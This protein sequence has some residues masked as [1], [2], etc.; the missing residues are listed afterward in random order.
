MAY[1]IKYTYEKY[2]DE[3]D[4]IGSDFLTIPY[5]MKKI[6]SSTYDFI[7]K[8]IKYIENTEEISEDIR[9]LYKPFSLNTVKLEEKKWGIVYPDDFMYLLRANVIDQ[10]VVVR[11]TN[12]IR[13][14]QLDIYLRNPHT[15]PT[16]HYPIVVRNS[17]ILTIISDGNPIKLDGVYVKKPIFGNYAE[18]IDIDKEIIVNLPDIAVE[19]ILQ[20]AVKST[21]KSLNDERYDAQNRETDDFR[22]R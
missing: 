18:G 12:V 19:K 1:T 2:L 21:Y 10:N 17:D 3:M 11:K 15:R 5:M 16:A 4:K 6:I 20:L 22:T 14:S 9:P 8:T 7:G 13:N